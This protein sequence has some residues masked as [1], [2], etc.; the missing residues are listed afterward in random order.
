MNDRQ[1]AE[2][3]Q[4]IIG[5]MNTARGYG[6]GEVQVSL[7]YRDGLIAFAEIAPKEQVKF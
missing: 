7:K 4:K 3:V 2:A 1:E 5:A 6:H